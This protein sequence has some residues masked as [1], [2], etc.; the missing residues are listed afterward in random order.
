M[1]VSDYKT[2]YIRSRKN[3]ATFNSITGFTSD[4]NWITVT[5]TTSFTYSISEN[6]SSSSRT[7]TLTLTQGESGKKCY[8]V[9]TQQGADVEEWRYTFTVVPSTLN[10]AASGGTK[11]CTVTSYK[12]KWING[13][14]QP[15]T[16]TNVNWSSTS[17]NSWLSR[18]DTSTTSCAITAEENTNTISR[19]GSISFTQSEST[20]YVNVVCTQD[21]KVSDV[22]VFTWNDGSESAKSATIEA[23]LAEV[24]LDLVYV[25]I[26]LKNGLEH[27]WSVDSKPSW[28][29][30]VR[31]TSGKLYIRLSGANSS[32]NSRT[33][34]IHLKQ[35]MSGYVLLLS[36]TQKGQEVSYEFAWDAANPTLFTHTVAPGTNMATVPAQD[37]ISQ[38]SSDGWATSSL[39]G[40]TVTTKP[41][42][43]TVSLQPNQLDKMLSVILSGTAPITLGTYPVTITQNESGEAV[44]MNIVVEGKPQNMISIKDAEQNGTSLKFMISATSTVRSTI[45]V[46]YKLST[47][48]GLHTVE[49]SNNWLIN[50]TGGVNVTEDRDIAYDYIEITSISPTSDSTYNYTYSTSKVPITQKSINLSADCTFLGSFGQL[51][52][53]DRAMV[54]PLGNVVN[55]DGS[56]SSIGTYLT[57]PAEY[58]AAGSTLRLTG[59]VTFNVEAH[60]S[61]TNSMTEIS[62]ELMGSNSVSDVGTDYGQ[63]I[64]SWTEHYPVGGL[65]ITVETYN[66][67]ID[68]PLL[69]LQYDNTPIYLWFIT[70]A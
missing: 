61:T 68:E 42:W 21:Q 58:N 49:D 7:G 28:V 53:S 25:P 4:A 65:Y 41:S 11:S 19:G 33:G 38:K 64:R 29:D 44:M 60:N 12:V 1:T 13:V 54:I 57:V 51:M 27:P 18:V 45:T 46:N 16:K 22:Y 59:A 70:G 26:S 36:F 47:S 2:F 40:A 5:S 35:S 37:L 9:I 17:N 10:F 31:A 62:V 32:T 43:L 6:T 56:T 55:F 63:L 52:T 67:S 14:E 48:D 50:G 39:V 20:N 34:T 69:D 30:D 66:E 15:L 3:G 8:I 23:T 24:Y